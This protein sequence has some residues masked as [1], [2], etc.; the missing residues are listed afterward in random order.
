MQK[1]NNRCDHIGL[2]SS[3]TDRLV[4]FYIKKLGFKKIKKELLPTSIA[5]PLFDIPSDCIFLKL[6]SG[7][8]MIELFEPTSHSLRKGVYNTRGIHHWGFC[9]GDKKKFIAR[10]KKKGVSIIT[11][12]RNDHVAYFITD[13]DGNKIEIRGS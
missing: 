4:A 13:P 3:N 8:V 1:K 10:L 12:T 7:D 9:V 5:K 11:I 6:V 2:V